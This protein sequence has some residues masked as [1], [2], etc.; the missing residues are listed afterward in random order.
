MSGIATAI[1]GSAVIGGVVS[2]RAAKGAAQTQQ[3]ATEAGIA[4]EQRQFDLN[5]QDMAPYREAG[6]AVLPQLISGLA[7]AGGYPRT[8]SSTTP[9]G[10]SFRP[11]ATPSASTNPALASFLVDGRGG[12]N[13]IY[14]GSIDP[15]TGQVNVHTPGTSNT[16][17]ELSRLATE[18]LRTG[19]GALQGT[20]WSR[21]AQSID[22][23]RSKGYQYQPGADERERV[24]PPDAGESGARGE[25]VPQQGAAPSGAGA[26]PG[27]FNR[28]FTLADFTADPGY[29]FRVEQGNKGIERAASVSGRTRAPATAMA[30]ARYNSGLANQEFN[31]S[32]TRWNADR[33]RRFNRLSA[34]AGTGQTATTNTAQLGSASAGRISDLYT[35]GGNARAAGQIGVANAVNN[36][37]T[38]LSNFY[39]QQQLLKRLPVTGGGP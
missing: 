27:D 26:P 25:S 36:G 30:L 4:E 38:S 19:Q 17:P 1:V 39:L 24:G 21:F 12:R 7:P 9:S 22:G 2:S 23:L 35:Q 32:Y 10:G 3:Q 16:D 28:D 18:Y 34:L 33:D 11:T 5:R 29:Q 14:G 6:L 37:I 20:A 8:A 31:D 15:A 13:G